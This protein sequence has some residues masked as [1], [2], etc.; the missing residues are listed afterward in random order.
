MT[1][2]KNVKVER[3]NDKVIIKFIQRI[4]ALALSCDEAIELASILFE[5]AK[6]RK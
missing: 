5:H 6:E 1:A 2:H 3:L 4:D